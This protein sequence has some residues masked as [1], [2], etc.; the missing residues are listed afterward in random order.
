MD[1]ARSSPQGAHYHVNVIYLFPLI[2]NKEGSKELMVLRVLPT[3]TLSRLTV[4]IPRWTAHHYIVYQVCAAQ[5]ACGDIFVQTSARGQMLV[6]Y[7]DFR[8]KVK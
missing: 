8:D 5:V 7:E 4:F 6:G 2:G 3:T 1:I